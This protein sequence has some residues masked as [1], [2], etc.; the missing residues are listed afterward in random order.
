M[1]ARHWGGTWVP[2]TG[3]SDGLWA[4]FGDITSSPQPHTVPPAPHLHLKS[5][6]STASW[7]SASVIFVLQRLLLRG[8]IH[9]HIFPAIAVVLPISDI[10]TWGSFD[11]QLPNSPAPPAGAVAVP[12]ARVH[13]GVGDAV[14]RSGCHPNPR[15]CFKGD[16]C[17]RG[18]VCGSCLFLLLRRVFVNRV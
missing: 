18:D 17:L 1:A 13:H 7:K 11:A 4:L 14:P 3:R 10:K 9:I 5:T 12:F 16:V 2:S 8:A 15:R 6:A